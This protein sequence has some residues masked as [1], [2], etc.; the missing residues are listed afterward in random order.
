MHRPLFVYGTLRDAEL[1]AAV[2]GRVL[3]PNG[4]AAAAA[5]G[6]RAAEIPGRPYPALL[7]APGCAAG[8]LLLLGI[9]PFEFDLLDAYEGE[10]YRRTPVPVMVEGELHTVDAYLP[11]IAVPATA[12]DWS[13]ARWQA[14]HKAAS[15]PAEAAAAAHLHAR[16][17]A[18][19][20]H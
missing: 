2:L 4:I 19:R 11:A 12:A 9:T 5:P 18:A 20:P 14:R 15:L 1:R 8:G 3:D 16:L 6:Y 10:E 7:H 17:L 13:L